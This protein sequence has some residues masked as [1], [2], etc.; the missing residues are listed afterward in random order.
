MIVSSGSMISAASTRG[1]TSFLIGS[2][3][4]VLSAS[5]CSVTRIEPSWAAMPEP[6]LPATIRPARTG[7]S[8]RT[9]D[10]AISFPMSAVCPRAAS[11][12]ELCNASTMPVKNPVRST[13]PREPTP[14]TSIC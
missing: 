9:I 10:P 13:I 8:S 11:C 3:P 6:T 1:V 5:I 2:V 4:S 7:P 12:T 14:I